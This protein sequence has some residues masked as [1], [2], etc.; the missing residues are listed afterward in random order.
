MFA[1]AHHIL[2]RHYKWLPSARRYWS[3]TFVVRRSR[4]FEIGHITR[5]ILFT[6]SLLGGLL[7]CTLVLNKPTIANLNGVRSDKCGGHN[8]TTEKLSKKRRELF[9]VLAVRLSWWNG[10]LSH[11]YHIWTNDQRCCQ[12]ICTMNGR[13]KPFTR[14]ALQNMFIYDH[15]KIIIR[16]Q[17]LIIQRRSVSPGFS[18]KILSLFLVYLS[19]AI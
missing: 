14:R 17:L 2:R 5:R 4:A 13:S 19:V 18:P 15:P 3:C 6:S 9:V 11:V 8:P 1:F 16:C 10:I 12:N 7:L